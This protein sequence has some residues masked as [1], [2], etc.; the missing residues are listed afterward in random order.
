[1]KPWITEA[2]GTQKTSLPS[3]VIQA[4]LAT[5][6]KFSMPGRSLSDER[7]P[8]LEVDEGDVEGPAGDQIAG[9]A[10]LE[11]RVQD[12]VVLGG[13]RGREDHLDVRVVGVEGRDDGVLPDAQVVVA[14]ALDGERG[15]LREGAADD[16]ED[17]ERQQEG[18]DRAKHVNLLQDVVH[19]SL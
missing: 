12:R 6:E 14:P 11:P 9:A 1:M 2:I 7:K 17:R 3:S 10:R 16:R 19:V 4:L 18:L 8:R 15:A 5:S 13:C